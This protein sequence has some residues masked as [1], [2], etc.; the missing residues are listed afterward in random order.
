MHPTT[1]A[2]LV[3]L[4]IGL[5]A[6]VLAVGVSGA[7]GQF[8]QHGAMPT[9]GNAGHDASVAV[10]HS[11]PT[12]HPSG[13]ITPKVTYV[14]NV[15]GYVTLPLAVSGWFNSSGGDYNSTS[16]ALWATVANFT[17]V[18]LAS[19]DLNSSF[20]A[21]P[22]SASAFAFA[23]NATT[24][25][26]APNCVNIATTAFSI[27]TYGTIT[28]GTNVTTSKAIG[29]VFFVTVPISLSLQVSAVPVGTTS[30]VN[31]TFSSKE[32]G[33]YITGVSVTVF[34]AT[35]SSVPI[36]TA[37]LVTASG[38]S[39]PASLVVSSGTYAASTTLVTA[40]GKTLVANSTI[41]AY[42][43]SSTVY[44]NSTSWHNQTFFGGL[45]PAVAGTILLIVGLIVGLIVA[46]V[47]GRMVWGSTK[48]APAQPWTDAKTANVC[49]VCGKSFAT[50]EELAAHGKSEHGMQ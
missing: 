17:G 50:P 42:A 29:T 35:N 11:A 21:T 7:S 30:S 4:A 46:M 37:T 45:S 3:S 1:R 38:S 6:V 19:F 20:N 23:V 13:T 44:S 25:G 16:G 5:I 18:V 39:T 10:A 26:C 9:V 8:A 41:A 43:S 22:T 31:V 36:F 47:L 14:P 33:Q 28:N 24:L 34:S 32:T 15:A 12:I 27:V 48:P 2:T 49:S 40:Y